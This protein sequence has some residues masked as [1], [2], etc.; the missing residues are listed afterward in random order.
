MFY[1]CEVFLRCVYFITLNH[2]L[3]YQ[4]NDSNFPR[5]T[6]IFSRLGDITTAHSGGERGVP[7]PSDQA[8]RDNI[9]QSESLG[10]IYQAYWPHQ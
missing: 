4:F 6:K 2:T 7:S 1:Q 10:G 9:N 8:R 3:A 5:L